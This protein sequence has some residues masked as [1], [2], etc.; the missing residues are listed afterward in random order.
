MEPDKTGGE[1]SSAPE[2]EAIPE[3][4]GSDTGCQGENKA[5]DG[6][7]ASASGTSEIAEVVAPTVENATDEAHLGDGDKISE[8]SVSENIASS[9]PASSSGIETFKSS[10]NVV[11]DDSGT[12]FLALTYL[13]HPPDGATFDQPYHDDFW[14]CRWTR[15]ESEIRRMLRK[16]S[17]L[18]SD[19]ITLDSSSSSSEYDSSEYA[20]DEYEDSMASTSPIFV[21][22]KRT[23]GA[24]KDSS[25]DVVM[26]ENSSNAIV[27]GDEDDIDDDVVDDVDA[28]ND[29]VDEIVCSG[30][31]N[32]GDR[33]ADS[34]IVI[35]DGESSAVGSSQ[36]FSGTETPV[37]PPPDG[38]S[39]TRDS[40]VP[41]AD[42]DPAAAPDTSDARAGSGKMAN[43]SADDPD[44]AD[45]TDVAATECERVK[46]ADV[47]NGTCGVDATN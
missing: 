5:R 33:D 11:D 45:E 6:E 27:V 20:E 44:P 4:A 14:K 13:V 39:A 16:S 36:P 46:D 34:S 37:A 25:G 28:E 9:E 1:T 7:T 19:V 40:S 38:D 21:C 29:E 18:A 41:G 24:E 2:T 30:E 8:K 10:A 43:G 42:S 17:R 47:R 32:E 15:M 35:C 26:D 23:T 22:E 3:A 31:T 12:D